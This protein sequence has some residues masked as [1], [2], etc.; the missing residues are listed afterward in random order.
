MITITPETKIS[1][2]IKAN[3]ASIEAIASINPHFNK[4]RNPILRKILASRVTISEAARIGKCSLTNFADKL[5]PLGF[6]LICEDT[7]K[8]K[9]YDD[10]K[11]ETHYDILLDV[12][13]NLSKGNDPFNIIMKALSTLQGGHTLLL[14][15]SF[16]PFPLIKILERKKYIITVAHIDD[17]LV[18]TYLQKPG[19]AINEDISDEVAADENFDDLLL[20]YKGKMAETDV[21]NMPM[22]QPML[23]ILEQ[24]EQLPV[25]M[26]LFVYHKKVPMFLLPEL[27]QNGY[28]YAIKQ[29]SGTVLMLIYR[30]HL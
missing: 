25:D 22:P 20:V 14:I 17:N 29:N 23:H 2:L 5:R 9:Q 3:A 18:H 7:G 11:N 16:E 19:D 27:K 26:A 1:A 8:T 12:R 10:S 6:D 24:L 28:K 4:L 30:Q 15:N 21:R 13:D